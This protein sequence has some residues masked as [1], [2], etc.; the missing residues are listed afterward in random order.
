M[1]SVIGEI[2]VDMVKDKNSNS[3]NY[4]LGGAPLNVAYAINK[5]QNDV[6]F[7]GNV[8]NDYLGTFLK[9]EVKNKG[10]DNK[11]I[12]LDKKHNTTIAFVINDSNGERSF[13]FLRNNCADYYIPSKAFNLIKNA[14]IVHIGSLMLSTTNGLKFANK[15]IKIAKE[16]NKIISFDIN[17]REDIYDSKEKAINV[18]KEIYSKCDIIKVSEEELSML[19]N[20]NNIEE[21]LKEFAY[22]NQ[23]VFVTLGAKGSLL[24]FNNKIIKADTIKVNPIDTTGAGDAFY[25]TIL[26]LIDKYGYDNFFK[27]EVIIKNSLKEANI[28]GAYATLKKG[29]I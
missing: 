11:Y 2:L 3:F 4:F 7:I 28:Q 25:G 9:Q 17:Y 15:L 5:I 29:A 27:D 6:M 22:T 19:T 26:G 12:F 18:S 1:I 16:H 8:G 23:K 14:N 13:S 24:Y 10:L 21:A 20:K